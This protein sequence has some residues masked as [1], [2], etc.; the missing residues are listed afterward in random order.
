MVKSSGGTRGT[1]WRDKTTFDKEK[2][3]QLQ[4][5]WHLMA[6]TD[7][8]S[9]VQPIANSMNQ[10]I[11]MS[12][13][14]SNKHRQVDVHNYQELIPLM[15]GFAIRYP[16]EMDI[17]TTHDLAHADF[18]HGAESLHKFSEYL[19]DKHGWDSR[20]QYAKDM[21]AKPKTRRKKK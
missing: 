2:M 9:L 17:T 4:D 18:Y 3:M 8:G 10:F 7:L 19:M 13:M 21:S 14:D 6:T 16:K 5:K 1:S 12:D 11:A 15:R 20:Y